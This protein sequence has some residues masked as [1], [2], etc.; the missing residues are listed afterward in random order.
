MKN[1]NLILFLL[2][3]AFPVY[4]ENKEPEVAHEELT[5]KI[6]IQEKLGEIGEE[7]KEKKDIKKPLKETLDNVNRAISSFETSINTPK[8]FN[9]LNK[10]LDDLQTKKDWDHYYQVRDLFL[11][12]VNTLLMNFWDDGAVKNNDTKTLVNS[13]QGVVN[14]YFPGESSNFTF[15]TN[16]KYNGDIERLKERCTPEN[17]KKLNAEVSNVLKTAVI[18]ISA[19]LDDLDEGIKKLNAQRIGLLNNLEKKNESNESIFRWGFP[20]F[21]LFILSLYLVPLFLF[22]GRKPHENANQDSDLLIYSSIYGTGLVT[23]IITV[24]LLTSTILLLG[25]TDKIKGEILG[26]LIGGISGYVLGRAFKNTNGNGNGTT[27][28]PKRTNSQ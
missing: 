12:D 20:V 22:K 13:I 11:R 17:M 10:N 5:N 4:S 1:L 7:I 24:F 6:E 8:D 25:L 3:I 26:T 18:N 9:A 16:N 23:E 28:E 21:I 19:K 27:I 15:G 2:M 14:T